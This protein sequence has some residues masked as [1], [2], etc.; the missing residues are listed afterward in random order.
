MQGRGDVE[1]TTDEIM[2]H[3]RNQGTAS[4]PLPAFSVGAHAAIANLALVTRGARRYR[5]YFP[6]VRLAAPDA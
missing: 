1:M 2:A 6:I 5:T 3:R 4:V